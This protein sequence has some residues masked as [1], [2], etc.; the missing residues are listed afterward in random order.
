MKI[1]HLCYMQPLKIDV[2]PSDRV[3]NVYYD[4]E[5]TQKTPNINSDKA[6]VHVPNMVLLQ[7]LF[8]LRELG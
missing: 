4:F 5:T 8:A 7:Q 2:P 1:G 6:T 3:L